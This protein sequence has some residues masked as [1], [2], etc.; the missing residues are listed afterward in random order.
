[1][2]RDLQGY[3]MQADRDKLQAFLAIDTSQNA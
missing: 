3:E 2:F 1:M